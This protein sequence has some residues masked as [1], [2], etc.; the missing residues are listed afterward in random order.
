M[1]GSQASPGDRLVEG[2]SEAGATPR[3][4]RLAAVTPALGTGLAVLI[5]L[6]AGLLADAIAPRGPVTT[7]QGLAVMAIAL[8]AGLAGGCLARTRWVL[9]PQLLAYAVAVEVGR[10]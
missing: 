1:D 10:T 2:V 9:L 5:A 8:L 7:G 6:L 3:S 4:H